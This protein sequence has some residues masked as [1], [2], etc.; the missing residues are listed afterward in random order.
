MRGGIIYAMRR[1]SFSSLVLASALIVGATSV[2]ADTA[3]RGD[4]DDAKGPLDI[5]RIRH[6]HITT[7]RGHHR[8]VHEIRLYERWPVRKLRHRGFVNVFFEVEETE[9]GTPPER[10]VYISYELG[11]LRAELVEF[12]PPR[13]LRF[14]RL[15]RPDRRTVRFAL[16]RSDLSEGSFDTYRWHAVSY[17]EEDHR[18][19]GETGGC[20]DQ[21]PNRGWVRHDL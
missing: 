10:A 11:R 21:A 14:L 18:L 6:M 9:P 4:P 3:G 15:W 13:S 8:L 5:A 2:S 1:A 7:E 20:D 12:D 16:R 19:C 17:I